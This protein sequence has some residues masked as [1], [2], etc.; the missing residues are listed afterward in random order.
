MAWWN[1][2]NVYH[3]TKNR[4]GLFKERVSLWEEY[5]GDCLVLATQRVVLGLYHH[6]DH[7]GAC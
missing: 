5:E 2:Q 6:W 7:L 1:D 3:S 4:P